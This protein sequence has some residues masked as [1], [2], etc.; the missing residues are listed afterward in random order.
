MNTMRLAQPF[1][2]SQCLLISYCMAICIILIS[3]SAWS[4]PRD[5]IEGWE[6]KRDDEGIQ[7]YTSSVTD[8]KFK[9]VKALMQ[10][11]T[12]LHALTA[13]VQDAESCPDWADLCKEA[14]VVETVSDTE[15]YVYTLNDLP[16]PVADRDAVAHVVW[17]QLPEDA[18]V[19]M[20]ATVAPDKL[21]KTK[22]KV[23]LEYGYT[24]WKFT[25]MEN[26]EIAVESF[27]HVDPGGATPAWLTNRL[28][29]ESPFVT[30]KAMR[31]LIAEGAY[32]DTTIGFI[33]N[34]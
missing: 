31:K 2:Q 34:P 6:L 24:S 22:G 19:M 15:M 21:P 32:Q 27:A 3:S 9:A 13:L 25:P 5:A 14:K 33:S 20:H 29:T 1:D 28:L 23:R 4:N 16:W 7:I 12:T 26:G 11:P 30:L 8:S 10:I 17:E 18:S